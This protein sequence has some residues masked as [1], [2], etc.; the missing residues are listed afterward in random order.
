[1][2][3]VKVLYASPTANP[4]VWAQPFTVQIATSLPE[5]NALLGNSVLAISVFR[6]DPS[7]RRVQPPR[8]LLS[9]MYPRIGKFYQGD[10]NDV[11]YGTDFYGVGQYIDGPS[12][13]LFWDQWDETDDDFFGFDLNDPDAGRQRFS[14]P[15]PRLPPTATVKI[16]S[17]AYVH[18]PDWDVARGIIDST[19]RE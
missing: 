7:R 10:P 1:M 15:N 11:I 18:P 8:Q 19:L 3:E 5:L 17:G 2:F 13:W 14:R 9:R 12:D 6:N 4:E 16:F